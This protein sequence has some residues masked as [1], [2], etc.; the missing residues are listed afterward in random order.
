MFKNY[1][2]KYQLTTRITGLKAGCYSVDFSNKSNE[3]AFTDGSEHL[4]ILT[5]DFK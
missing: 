2:H 3:F 5:Y 4:S 1:G